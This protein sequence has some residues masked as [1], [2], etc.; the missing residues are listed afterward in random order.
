MVAAVALVLMSFTALSTHV[1]AQT[2]TAPLTFLP[3]G[4]S[5]LADVYFDGTA[6]L[7]MRTQTVTSASTLSVAVPVNGGFEV[8]LCPAKAGATSCS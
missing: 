6:G 8:H 1:S 3:A 2:A 7:A 5:W 4:T